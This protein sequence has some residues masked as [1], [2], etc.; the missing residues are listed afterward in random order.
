MASVGVGAG[1]GAAMLVEEDFLSFWNAVTRQNISKNGRNWSFSCDASWIGGIKT[2]Y[3]RDC[4]V[5]LAD[6]LLGEP[7][8]SGIPVVPLSMALIL[9][10][11]GIGKTMFLNYLIV[12]IVEKARSDNTLTTLSIVYLHQPH[13][14]TEVGIR[15]TSS[16]CT[17]DARKADYYLSDSLDVADGTS[18]RHLLLEVASESNSNYKKFME[19]LTEKN[20]KRVIMNVWTLQELYQVKRSEWTDSE[21][22]F[23]HAVFGGRVRNCLGGDLDATSVDDDLE[24]IA[25]WFF[26]PQ[27]KKDYEKSWNRAL[28]LIRETMADA[29]GKTSKEELAIQTSLFWVINSNQGPG[30]SSTFLKLV[31]GVLSE[32]MEASLWEALTRLVGG[33]GK[34]LFFEAV[35][36]MKLTQT[37][38]EYTSRILKKGGRKTFTRKFNFPK[39]LIRC[40]DDILGLS[41]NCYG[42][43][44]FGNFMLVDAIIKPNIMLQFTVAVTHG[45]LED[46]DKWASIRSSLGG[47][48]KND[49]LIFVIPASNL[50]CFTYR[51]VPSDLECYVMTWEEAVNEKVTAGIKRKREYG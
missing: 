35:G 33:S 44:L 39:V 10:P 16:G 38:K 3:V 13:G 45:C 1:V 17:V 25:F 12:R 27:V 32:K 37:D 47:I 26:G 48:R 30:F 22:D 23:L 46:V 8:P 40:V 20:G 43:P 11:K 15:F 7:L 6:L 18:G 21:V 41:D 19:R 42:I 24:A 49:K 2:M 5:E 50:G 51:G 31:A 29:R 4:Y 34:G 14:S 36:H 9:G 28:K